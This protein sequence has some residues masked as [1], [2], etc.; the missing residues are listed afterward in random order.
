M[1]WPD[2]SAQMHRLAG[3]RFAPTDLTTHW[4]GL[5]GVPLP[6]LTAAVSLAQK[7]RSA[8][9]TPVE[10][11]E[12]AD[13]VAHTVVVRAPEATR[14]VD[15]EQPFTITV[16]QAGVVVSVTREWRYHCETC[17]DS[18]WASVWCGDG[19]SPK[20]WHTLVTCARRHPHDPHGFV[21]ACVCWET[22][23]A[24]VRRRAAQQ[25]YAEKSR[26]VA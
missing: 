9:P 3:L 5:R 11:R 17:A 16:P 2:F 14:E 6:V 13:R 1:T 4:E 21:R 19:P 26:K 24:L 7:T 20:P 8:F 15:L 10:L 18:G 25:Q 22:N 12:D 23:P